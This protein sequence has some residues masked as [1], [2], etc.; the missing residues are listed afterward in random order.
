MFQCLSFFF[1]HENSSVLKH[2]LGKNH[3][4]VRVSLT[5]HPPYSHANFQIN[6]HLGD[7]RWT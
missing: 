5:E 4:M 3:K 7:C 6:S 2:E 1:L